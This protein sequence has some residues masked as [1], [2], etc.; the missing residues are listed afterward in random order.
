[1][2]NRESNDMLGDGDREKMEEIL[3]SFMPRSAG[4]NHAQLMFRAGQ[5]SARSG[6][7]QSAFLRWMWPIAC[8]AMVVVTAV[9]AT[10]LAVG[11]EPQVRIVERIVVVE[12]PRKAD[13]R[14]TPR[15]PPN[16]KTTQDD[17][18]DTDEHPQFVNSNLSIHLAVARRRHLQTL[19]EV[20]TSP[21][22]SW[23]SAKTI[24][25]MRR[26]LFGGAE[27]SSHKVNT[28]FVFPPNSFFGD[29]L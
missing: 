11:S 6:P 4:V 16:A 2:A 24:G 17:S 1:M 23:E 20:S 26:D 29:N 19:T 21:I 22:R 25:Q 14:D 28:F 3:A 9:L 5:E 15:E 8:G 18:N 13:L 7:R 27:S 12:Q 10:L